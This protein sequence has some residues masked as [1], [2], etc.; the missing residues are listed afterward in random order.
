MKQWSEAF[1][2]S[3]QWRNCR[4]YV[5]KRDRGLCQD[6]L[7]KNRIAPAEEVHHITPLT[8]ENITDPGI[9]LNEKNLISLCR[10]CHR[11][12]HSPREESL[13]YTVDEIGRVIIK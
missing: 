6:C 1:Y 3:T 4:D 5:F 9:T 8:P 11:A 13:R 12:R 2:N 10:K 7:K